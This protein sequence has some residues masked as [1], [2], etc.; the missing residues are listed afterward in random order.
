[1]SIHFGH[2]NEYKYEEKYDE[3]LSEY[4]WKIRKDGILKDSGTT[5]KCLT[6]ELTYGREDELFGGM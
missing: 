3:L 4:S 1:M 2:E 6:S 5:S